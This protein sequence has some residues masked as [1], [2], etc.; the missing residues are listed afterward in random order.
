MVSIENQIAARIGEIVYTPNQLADMLRHL[1]VPKAS[2]LSFGNK[3]REYVKGKLFY[4]DLDK[5]EVK[6][7]RDSDTK[8]WIPKSRLVDIVEGMKLS[9]ATS[10]RD[11]E[12][13]ASDLGYPI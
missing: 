2:S 13:A 9:Q 8:Y 4:V 3:I 12:K 5:L 6:P 1:G 10:E 11:L 7:A